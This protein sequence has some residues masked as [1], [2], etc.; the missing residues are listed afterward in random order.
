MG[1]VLASFE[2]ACARTITFYRKNW[3]ELPFCVDGSDVTLT[4][5]T[6]CA[7][8]L[9]GGVERRIRLG[10]P[11]PLPTPPEPLQLELFGD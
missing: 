6:A 5:P 9:S 3:R 1:L 2:V 10:T 7:Q 11:G 8:K 4:K